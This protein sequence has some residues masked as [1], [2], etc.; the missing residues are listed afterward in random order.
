MVPDGAVDIPGTWA[1][2][3]KVQMQAVIVATEDL[4]R[5]DDL[6]CCSMLAMHHLR[7]RMQWS[8]LMQD[9]LT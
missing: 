7:T 9:S 8:V 3:R 1:A 4:I 6:C 2:Q 5:K